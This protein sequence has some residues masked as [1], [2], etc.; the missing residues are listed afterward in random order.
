[1]TPE[2]A[3]RTLALLRDLEAELDAAEAELRAIERSATMIGLELAIAEA[4]LDPG[5]LREGDGSPRQA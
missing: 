5:A 1:M 3:G 4:L 2:E